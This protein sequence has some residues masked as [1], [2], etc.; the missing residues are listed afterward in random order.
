MERLPTGE[1]TLVSRLWLRGAVPDPQTA[2][3]RL[4]NLLGAADLRPRSL[5][6]SAIV[7]V[8]RLSAPPLALGRRHGGAQSPHAWGRAVAGTLERLAAGAARPIRG[9]VP[10]TAEAVVFADRAELLASLALDWGRQLIPT[11]WWWRGILGD[12]DTLRP[13]ISE[14]LAA[15]E[16]V[17]AALE[18]LARAGAAFEFVRALGTDEAREMSR[19][20]A[21]VYGLQELCGALAEPIGEG[22]GESTDSSASA[23]DASSASGHAVSTNALHREVPAPPWRVLIPETLRL[24]LSREQECLLGIGL[25]HARAPALARAPSFASDVRAWRSRHGM[26]LGDYNSSAAGRHEEAFAAPIPRASLSESVEAERVQ[27][28]PAALVPNVA[29]EVDR[30]QPSRDTT[31]GR[32]E[33][34]VRGAFA[35]SPASQGTPAGVELLEDEGAPAAILPLEAERGVGKSRVSTGRETPPEHLATA[36]DGTEVKGSYQTEGAAGFKRQEPTP[37][38]YLLEGGVET[39]LGGLFYLVNLGIF[40]GLYGDFTNPLRPGLTL[41]MWDFVALMGRRL[42]EEYAGEEARVDPAWALLAR[43][44][45]R[46]EDDPPGL[47][48]EPPSEWRVPAPWLSPFP[49][50]GPWRWSDDGLRL[51]ARH[52]EG[53]TI[54]DVTREGGD[55]V[56]QLRNE[57]A[58]YAHAGSFEMQR[59]DACEASATCGPLETWI[60]WLCAYAGARLYR[61][62]G[63]HTPREA[64]RLLFEQE[65]RVRMT[66]THLEVLYV[67]AALPFEVRLSGLDR[68]PGWVPAAGR[69][70]RFV[71]E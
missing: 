15:P 71:Y 43:L 39:K 59:E 44:A 10:P 62:L 6:A 52:P 61:A 48:F 36:G 1:Q 7:C 18:H 49:E 33:A 38:P 34:D 51:R 46:A 70:V 31:Q 8:R 16:Y 66:A 40:L 14:W 45:G 57:A 50:A 41:P 29:H 21:R 67:L 63:T 65:A 17:P 68:D 60:G 5:P 58:A 2:R 27:S 53:F 26:T 35:A 42:C 64:L 4:E 11:R 9:P 20:V 22:R 32:M 56:R 3:L 28:V 19:R 24:Q 12:G 55:P 25:T 54:F 37:P 30:A 13:L 23:R 69:F 47:H